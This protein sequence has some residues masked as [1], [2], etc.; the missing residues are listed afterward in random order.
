[1]VPALFWD[2]VARLSSNKGVLQYAPT[3]RPYLPQEFSYESQRRVQSGARPSDRND[4]YTHPLTRKNYRQRA[5]ALKVPKVLPK[6]LARPY[7]KAF[8][9]FRGRQGTVNVCWY[10]A[11][12]NSNLPLYSVVFARIATIPTHPPSTQSDAVP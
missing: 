4:F 10:T 12:L 1:M 2:A 3:I 11:P 9:G 7:S 6:V 5:P 8:V